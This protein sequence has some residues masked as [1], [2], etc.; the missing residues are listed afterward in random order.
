MHVVEHVLLRPKF[1]SNGQMQLINSDNRN[2]LSFLSDQLGKAYYTKLLTFT[3]NSGNEIQIS[4][5]YAGDFPAGEQFRIIN[6]TSNNGT[7]TVASAVT[8]GT[9]TVITLTTSTLVYGDDGI[10][11]VAV[12]KFITSYAL[13][14]KDI[15]VDDALFNTAVVYNNL[16]RISDSEQEQ[17]NGTYTL[18]TA[19]VSGDT[20]H[21][22]FS[23]NKF[24]PWN[25]TLGSA[26][27][28][29]QHGSYTIDGIDNAFI[30]NGD[31]VDDL[32]PNTRVL[33]T[34]SP[35]NDGYYTV[36]LAA[37]DG[38]ITTIKV[39]DVIADTSSS[40]GTLSYSVTRPVVSY[41]VNSDT[42]LNVDDALLVSGVSIV[43]AEVFIVNSR[44]GVN[45]GKY[46]LNASPVASGSTRLFSFSKR[47]AQYIDSFL[48]VDL[49]ADCEACR[50]DNP[51][52][53]I[54]SVILP[55][56][57]GRFRNHDFRAFLERT[58]RLEMPAHIAMNLCWLNCDHMKTFEH[59]YKDWLLE[60]AR[61]V[62]Q[63]QAI[64]FAL[65]DLIEILGDIR[66]QYPEGTLH[67]C[68]E[69][70][71]LKNSIVLNNTALGTF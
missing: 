60:N 9:D 35:M 21:W 66:S 27:Y 47:L 26:V 32:K 57:Q 58:I 50:N 19:P 52:S 36:Q 54:V 71:K 18:S 7:Y 55:A 24:T 38:I 2:T 20:Q 62:K 40:A 65:D 29:K 28:V 17:N 59:R 51:Y 42:D 25:S 45:D 56:W 64:T 5:H 16:V 70:P 37:Y 31:F 43:N 53:Y 30:I 41:V 34:G 1:N 12:S 22:T 8:A 69:D 15:V 61:K 46:T 13:N 63:P 4:G 67:S 44:D 33:I 68:D 48:P 10:V 14:G 23:F 39:V 3:V 6:T 11:L 49:D